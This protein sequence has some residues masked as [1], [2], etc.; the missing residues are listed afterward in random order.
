MKT[1]KTITIIPWIQQQTCSKLIKTKQIDT[2]LHETKLQI[3]L[4]IHTNTRILT[5]SKKK[6]WKCTN[7]KLNNY[8]QW[9]VVS[10]AVNAKYYGKMSFMRM[11]K[12]R[13][14]LLH[15]ICSSK[16]ISLRVRN[17][18]LEM[19]GHRN[20]WHIHMYVHMTNSFVQF[21]NGQLREKYTD[22][23]KKRKICFC[24]K[25]I[26]G[27]LSQPL[28]WHGMAWYDR[29]WYGAVWQEHVK[30][31]MHAELCVNEALRHFEYRLNSKKNER[32]KSTRTKYSVR[33]LN[34]VI[35]SII[36][37]SFVLARR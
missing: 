1:R 7:F 26:H 5:K 8:F 9:N 16:M 19:I 15:F 23:I 34:V 3:D 13:V 37:G 21:N 4:Y 14:L 35:I 12:M 36:S 18:I 25:N 11:N 20:A 28:V 29:I 30:D 10:S 27:V 32:K 33:I 31:S 6:S 22:I 2:F 24:R 17:F